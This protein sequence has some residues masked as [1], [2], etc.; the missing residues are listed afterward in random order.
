MYMQST[1]ADTVQNTPL[2]LGIIARLGQFTAA[3]VN[4][5]LRFE[6]KTCR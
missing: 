3:A 2:T 6:Y 5:Q 4:A 1:L